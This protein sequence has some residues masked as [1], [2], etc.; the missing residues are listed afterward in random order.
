LGD[1]SE[2]FR[3]DTLE[4]SGKPPLQV[5][6]VRFDRFGGG[7]Y[8]KSDFDVVAEWKDIQKMI[9]KFCEAKHSDAL[10]LREAM[11][12]AAGGSGPRVASTN[13]RCATIKLRH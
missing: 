7:D 12:L 2:N 6:A 9:E 13:A 1:Y 11:K 8:R 10:A 4:F 5:V 3:A